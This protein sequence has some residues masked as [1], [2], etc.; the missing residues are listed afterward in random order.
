MSR[1]YEFYI[2]TESATGG[3]ASPTS[4]QPAKTSSHIRR[5]PQRYSPLNICQEGKYVM[6]G[7]DKGEGEKK[8]RNGIRWVEWVSRRMIVLNCK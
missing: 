4:T 8:K 5:P 7:E 3:V 2:R 1:P 6:C